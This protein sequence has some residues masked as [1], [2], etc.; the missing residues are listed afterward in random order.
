[1]H[2]RSAVGERLLH[3]DDGG[4]L[5]VLDGDRPRA[6]RPRRTGRGRRRPATPSPT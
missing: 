6:R 3:V 5:L 2:Q 1:V 4:Q